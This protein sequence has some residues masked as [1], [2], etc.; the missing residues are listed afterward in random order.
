LTTIRVPVLLRFSCKCCPP[1]Q[2]RFS[3]KRIE[4]FTPS[5]GGDF[6]TASIAWRLHSIQLPS[7]S[8][9]PFPIQ[10]EGYFFF[11][12]RPNSSF[13]LHFFAGT[14]QCHTHHPTRWLL[15]FSPWKT[16]YLN[17]STLC[18]RPGLASSFDQSEVSPIPL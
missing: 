17:F 6:S 4:E 1:F 5:P 7:T 13:I 18:G 14:D 3:P 2:G 16:F 11:F 12:F 9:I 10:C 8:L 15:S